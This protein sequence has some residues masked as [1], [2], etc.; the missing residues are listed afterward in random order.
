MPG[1][2]DVVGER[3]EACGRAIEVP[4]KMQIHIEI[5]VDANPKAVN[6][7]SLIIT[8]AMQVHMCV[9]WFTGLDLEGRGRS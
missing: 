4:R 8:R 2:S 9:E 3:F 1:R 5:D 6:E 7:V